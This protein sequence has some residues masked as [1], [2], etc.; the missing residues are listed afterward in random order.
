MLVGVVEGQQLRGLARLGAQ[1]IDATVADPADQ[2]LRQEGATPGAQ[3]DSGGTRGVGLARDAA[4]DFSIGAEQRVAY[5]ARVDVPS[6]QRRVKIRNELAARAGSQGAATDT[7]GNDEERR[8]P[9][10]GAMP[11]LVHRATSSSRARRRSFKTD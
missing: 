10:Q 3:R 7:V 11:I 1:S 9:L 8:R 4:P 2:P 6:V 5:R